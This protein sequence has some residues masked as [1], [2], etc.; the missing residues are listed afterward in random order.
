MC[1]DCLKQS[2][3][4]KIKVP[5][6][7]LLVNVHILTCIEIEQKAIDSLLIEGVSSIVPLKN[8]RILLLSRHNL[9]N[10]MSALFLVR[11]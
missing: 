1:C 2:L 4:K 6:K 3:K 5:H 11:K 10:N 9:D 8:K 7:C